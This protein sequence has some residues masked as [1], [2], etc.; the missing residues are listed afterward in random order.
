MNFICTDFF[1]SLQAIS[2]YMI[3]INSC[4]V[5]YL[6]KCLKY[7]VF[8]NLYSFMS[9]FC[10][11]CISVYISDKHQLRFFFKNYQHIYI[12]IFF[13]PFFRLYCMFL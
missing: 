8:I 7:I 4:L 3:V 6:T 10:C 2:E 13:L 11:V 12:Y 9:S 5:R 1:F